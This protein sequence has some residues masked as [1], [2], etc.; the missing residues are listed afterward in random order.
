MKL[1]DIF[2]AILYGLSFLLIIYFIFSLIKPG[3]S[4]VVVYNDETP[5][6]QESVIYP[7]YS[8]YNWY[9]TWSPW[10]YWS[11]GDSGYYGRRGGYPRHH[12]GGDIRPWGRGG[13]GAHSGRFSGGRGGFGGR[14]GSRGGG[15]R[16]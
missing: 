2:F 11:G 12:W 7:W 13:R 10:S 6:S 4:T 1:S 9:Y 8:P 15:G 3:Q 16:R 14:G 5:V